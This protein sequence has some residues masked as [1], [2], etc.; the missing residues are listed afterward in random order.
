MQPLRLRSVSKASPSKPLPPLPTAGGS[1]VLNKAGDGW[2]PDA[3]TEPAPEPT[4]PVED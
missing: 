2:E 1:Y 4:E 3:P